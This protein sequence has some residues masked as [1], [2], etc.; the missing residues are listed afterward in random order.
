M[1]GETWEYLRER[2][3]KMETARKNTFT[4]EEKSHALFVLRGSVVIVKHP[5]EQ[6]AQSGA[7]NCWCGRAENEPMHNVV[8]V[9][10]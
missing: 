7:G 10:P 8:V 4:S 1:S 6:C 9:Q 3:G 2:R 5:Y